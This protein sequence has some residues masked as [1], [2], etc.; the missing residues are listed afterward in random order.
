MLVRKED[1]PGPPFFVRSKP[2]AAPKPRPTAS[3]PPFPPCKEK[4]KHTRAKRH[5]LD[6]RG[7][8]KF[9][10]HFPRRYAILPARK[11]RA[12][13]VELVDTHDSGSCGGNPVEVQILSSAP[14]CSACRAGSHPVRF[15]YAWGWERSTRFGESDTTLQWIAGD[16]RNTSPHRLLS[17]SLFSRLLE[18][19]RR[20]HRAPVAHQRKP[21]NDCRE[22]P[23]GECARF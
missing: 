1:P 23:P 7:N 17:T 19:F 3:A 16:H 9:A 21:E 5:P 20:E 12:E 11:E 13:V 4:E 2:E 15:F 14:S 18:T 22:Q 10:F 8:V 6:H